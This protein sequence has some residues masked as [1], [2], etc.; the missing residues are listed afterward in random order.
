MKTWSCLRCSNKIVKRS[1]LYVA[2]YAHN[3]G[4]RRVLH[5]QLV[6]FKIRDPVYE[7]QNERNCSWQVSQTKGSRNVVEYDKRVLL[8]CSNFVAFIDRY[9]AGT[10]MELMYAYEHNIPTYV[11]D[12][13]SFFRKDI[14][15]V[16]HTYEFFDEISDFVCFFRR[17]WRKVKNEDVDNKK[18]QCY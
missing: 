11:I 13:S 9:S 14:W 10:C 16:A 4:F 2:A 15:I 18:I 3:M 5:D 1:D 6:G 12:S 17:K 7:F 8:E